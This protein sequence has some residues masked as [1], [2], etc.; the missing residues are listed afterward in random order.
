MSVPF[1]DGFAPLAARYDAAILDLWGV[2]HNGRTVFP[3]AAECLSRMRAA[4]IKIALLSNAPRRSDIIVRQL[5]GIGVEGRAYD[6]VIT[7]GDL[8]RDALEAELGSGSPRFGQTYFHLGPARDAGLLD[9][10]DYRAV[11]DIEG[12]DFILNTGLFDDET[13][14]VADYQAQLRAASGRGQTLV[15]VNPDLTVIRGEAEIPCAGALARAYED[16]GGKVAYFGKPHRGA[17]DA[18]LARL[19]VTDRS[20]VVAIGDSLHTDVAGAAGAGLDAIFV[21]SGIHAAELGI[22][23]GE[24]PDPASLSKLLAGQEHP[25]VGVMSALAW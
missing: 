22:A 25:I 10:L 14:T 23:P 9:G 18:C 13:E 6:A 21:T 11:P 12:A 16:L 1:L 5:E 2:V 8:T 3:N 20:R 7:S 24:R 17:Y 19:G 4:G 15:C